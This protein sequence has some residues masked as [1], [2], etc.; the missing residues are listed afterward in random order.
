MPSGALA[1]W[2][3][4]SANRLDELVA[5]HASVGG[6]APGRRYATAQ[7][8]ASLVVQIA[9]HFQLLC[10]DLHSE[11]AQLL[12]GSAPT[13][14]QSMLR[15]A[16][17]NR[18]GLDRGNASAD[19]IASDFARFDL[20]IWAAAA[21]RDRRTAARRHRLEQ[22]NT[23]RNSIAHQDFFFSAQQQALLT[24]TSITLPWA[25][26]WRSACTGLAQTFDAVVGD[27]IA[28]VSGRRPW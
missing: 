28:A 10:R 18:R 2:R 20:D 11:A 1:T 7:L 8:N 6:T 23:W 9:A 17:T 5:A 22:L 27:H 21:M 3:S 25:R 15:V 13:A 16:F 19:T 24:G 12:A 14:Y 4:G 26:R